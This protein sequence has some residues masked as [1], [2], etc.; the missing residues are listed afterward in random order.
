MDS[1][2]KVKPCEKPTGR[3][4]T[5]IAC[6]TECLYVARRRA[7]STSTP[8]ADGEGLAVLAVCHCAE[9]YGSHPSDCPARLQYEAALCARPL[10][11]DVRAVVEKIRLNLDNEAKYRHAYGNGTAPLNLEHVDGNEGFIC[12][13]ADLRL[14]LAHLQ[15]EAK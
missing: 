2:T 7:R 1:E 4:L 9:Y 5:P 10:P 6:R 15:R 14:L 3:C 11:D 12:S 8:A 13:E